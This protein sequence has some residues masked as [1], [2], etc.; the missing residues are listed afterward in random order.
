MRVGAFAKDLRS[1]SNRTVEEQFSPPRKIVWLARVQVDCFFVF[2]LSGEGIAG[3]LGAI[4][5]FTMHISG[6]RRFRC[7]C[8]CFTRLARFQSGGFLGEGFAGA[9]FGVGAVAAGTVPVGATGHGA[10]R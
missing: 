2:P 4:A 3:T 6:A 9:Q 10:A 8:R 7:V 5:E 1:W